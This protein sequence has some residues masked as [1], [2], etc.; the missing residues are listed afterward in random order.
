MKCPTCGSE[1]S[2]NKVKRKARET[3]KERLTR[4]RIAGKIGGKA[5]AE[6]LTPARRSEIARMGALAQQRKRAGLI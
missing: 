2:E 5:R 3:K 1:V 6:S 4:M